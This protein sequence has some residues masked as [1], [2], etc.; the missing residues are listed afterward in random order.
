MTWPTLGEVEFSA[1]LVLSLGHF[2]WQGVAVAAAAFLAARLAGRSARARYLI[3]LSALSVMGLAPVL[4]FLILGNQSASTDRAAVAPRSRAAAPSVGIVAAATDDPRATGGAATTPPL[5]ADELGTQLPRS[6]DS[7]APEAPAHG[8]SMPRAGRAMPAPGSPPSISAAAREGVPLPAAA[9]GRWRR[10]APRLAAAYF[11]GVALM[12]ARLLLALSGARRL[13]KLAAP[14]TD[15]ELL[16]VLQ[17]VCRHLGMHRLPAMAACA[18]AGVPVLIGLV[19]PMILVPACLLTGLTPDQLRAVLAHEVAH[20]RRL[21]PWANLFQR[22]VEAVLFFHPAVWLV[23]G[24]LRAEREHCCDD[25]AASAA[26]E[27]RSRYAQ[28]LV[29]AAELCRIDC[30]QRVA[31]PAAGLAAL[32]ALG[33]PSGLRRRILRLLQGD[34]RPR[35]GGAAW[36]VVLLI[37]AALLA[38][39][40]WRHQPAGPGRA[41]RSLDS[42]AAALPI[43]TRAPQPPDAVDGR[44]RADD[45][46]VTEAIRV[47][48]SQGVFDDPKYAW[49]AC[50]RDLEAIGRDAVPALCREL[51]ASDH[52]F[53]QCAASLTLRAI[54]DR[55]AVPALIEALERCTVRASDCAFAIPS[56][57]LTAYYSDRQIEPRL[58]GLPGTVSLG[59]PVREIT[60]ALERLTGHSEGDSH[61]LMYQDN[62]QFPTEFGPDEDERERMLNRAVASRWRGWWE[63]NRAALLTAD[64]L[65]W[66]DSFKRA[67]APLTGPATRPARAMTLRA[68]TEAGQLAA[69]AEIDVWADG[70]HWVARADAD[71]RAVLAIPPAKSASVVVRRPGC[72][73]TRI[74]FGAA[75]ALPE[76]YD[77]AL[78]KGATV[79]GTVLSTVDKPAAG[80]RVFPVAAPKLGAHEW[81]NLFDLAATTDADGRWAIDGVPAGFHGAFRVEG[82]AAAPAAPAAVDDE[83]CGMQTSPEELAA[84]TAVWRIKPLYPVKGRV[85]DPAGHPVATARVLI[86]GRAHAQPVL[87]GD[88]GRFVV[89]RVGEGPAQLTVQ[90]ENFA[91]VQVEVG[92]VSADLAEQAITLQLPEP[93][94]GKVIDKSGK[95]VPDAVIRNAFDRTMRLFDFETRSGADG[96][97]AWAGAPHR[98]IGLAVYKDGYDVGHAPVNDGQREVTVTLDPVLEVSGAVVDARTR[99]PIVAFNV[100]EGRYVDTPPR[101]ATQRA[102]ATSSTGGAYDLKFYKGEG[103]YR[104]EERRFLRVEA[105][106]YKPAFSR[107]IDPG[108]GT[109][110]IDFALE[111]GEPI[112][113]K[114][115]SPT[116]APV[117]GAEVAISTPSMS[118][119]M[120]RG[121]VRR[122]TP[123]NI[124][125]AITDA[126]GGFSLP[127]QIEPFELVV[128]HDS[129]WARE[130]REQFEKQP[131]L[132]LAPWG[133]IEGEIRQEGQPAAKAQMTLSDSFFEDC[134]SHP[135]QPHVQLFSTQQTDAQG[136][137]VFPKVYPGHYRLSGQNRRQGTMSISGPGV[138]IDVAGGRTLN[139]SFG[140]EGQHATTGRIVIDASADGAEAGGPRAGAARVDPASIKLELTEAK[141]NDA[142]TKTDPSLPRV[143]VPVAADG[144][145]R[146]DSVK[147]GLWRLSTQV[148][149]PADPAAPDPR[150][151]TSGSAWRF[152]VPGGEGGPPI[153][154]G[155]LRLVLRQ[156]KLTAGQIAPPFQV[157]TLAGQPLRLRDLR[158]KYVLLDFWATWCGPCVA[159]TPNL[160]ATYDAFKADPRFEMISLSLDFDPARLRAYVKDNEMSWPQGLL[161]GNWE[162]AAVRA[163]GISGIPTIVLIGPDG[164]V[165]APDLRGAAIKSAVADALAHAPP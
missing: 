72:V 84:R 31:P 58:N 16:N 156:T 121:E 9:Q 52:G 91:S 150:G 99:R 71:G 93:L 89:P 80:V 24:R 81:A 114:I 113:G 142:G 61:L 95:P 4:T 117:T 49:V 130:T 66:V 165:I 25:L 131:T 124:L 21:D 1:R 23:S 67:A 143:R 70:D 87:T 162:S 88:D 97:F 160:K 125:F 109:V 129:G 155:D 149:V 50:V 105:A 151:F 161:D 15:R 47:F 46:R 77:V 20:L 82:S 119:D 34:P 108:D 141:P 33:R 12:L 41:G 55:R 94:T 73:P 14:V 148:D 76:R 138:P 147:A 22:L 35:P 133:R 98:G 43:A 159:E 56:P 123:E 157:K 60:A 134:R 154:L 152:E 132:A 18:Q 3:Y 6:E 158:G 79:G 106:G 17:A 104:R 42:A 153:P 2:L 62:G 78:H 118:A 144:T 103:M 48:S 8:P 101:R 57:E 136:R 53:F 10:Y 63:M 127:P 90:A 69:G 116:G 27:S 86:G 107:P 110:T 96:R 29:R 30:R 59:R 26:G 139:I 38:A 74:W 163:Y 37:A 128:S 137:Y 32:A 11:A 28:A 164:K 44:N 83:T 13:R 135:D 85:T 40:T 64:E 19:R 112:K 111:P 65:A 45:P 120:Y 145:F 7:G 5:W 92:R 100:L 102:M 75:D 115:V 68:T 122:H 39:F 140:T 36:P 51:R 126:G 54:G 146:I